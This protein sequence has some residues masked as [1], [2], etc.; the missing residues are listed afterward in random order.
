MLDGFHLPEKVDVSETGRRRVRMSGTAR[1]EQLLDVGRVLFA[2]KGFEATSIEE[3]AARAG[4]SKPVVYE[5]FGGKE[6]LYAVVVDREM[7]ALLDRITSALTGG[8]PRELVE[9][10]ALALLTYIEDETDGFRVLTRDAPV[11]SGHGTF[12]SLLIDIATQV[13]YILAR[14]F[15][16][17]GLQPKLAGM[18]AQMLVGMVALTGQ[19]W[20]EVRKPKREEVAAHLVNLGWNGLSGLE[21]KPTLS[22]KQR[23]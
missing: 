15:A 18:Y 6:G 7:S 17:R 13:E 4:V 20:L 3:V 21:A 14:E 10:A 16:E 9:Q 11:G 19:W 1:R 12:S 5:H 22:T 2:E 23:P 8:H